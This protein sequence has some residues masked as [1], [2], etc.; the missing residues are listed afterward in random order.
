MDQVEGADHRGAIGAVEDRGEGSDL[1]FDVLG[2]E[3][4]F[5]VADVEEGVAVDGLVEEVGCVLAVGGED[6][7]V[8]EGEDLTEAVFAV[9]DGLVSVVQNVYLV[10][11][12]IVHAHVEGYVDRHL[13]LDSV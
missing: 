5:E 6:V 10:P 11:E 12:N 2:E 3:V 4:V 1:V 7:F 8:E 9:E 13:D